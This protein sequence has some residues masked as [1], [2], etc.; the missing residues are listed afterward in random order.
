MADDKKITVKE[1][2]MW[3]Q[4]VEE[5]QD[6]GW[7]PTATQWKRIRDKID[8]IDDKPAAASRVVAPPPPEDG[9]PANFGTPVY[10]P[11]GM[12]PDPTKDL[13]G[14]PFLPE[15]PGLPARTPSIDTSNGTYGSPF[16]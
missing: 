1:F 16:I 5:M 12:M 10:A 4:G 13:A 8:L 2:T 14:K 15:Q 7:I 3:L 11:S 9:R 6:E